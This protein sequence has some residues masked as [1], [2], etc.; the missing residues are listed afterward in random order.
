MAT[1]SAQSTRSSGAASAYAQKDA[2]A[3]SA[4]GAAVQ[5]FAGRLAAV[6]A[7]HGKDG[8]RPMHQRDEAGR[9]VRDEDGKPVAATDSSG[10]TVY[11]SKYVQAYSLVES[12]GRDEL[13]PDDPESWQVAQRC[14]RALAEEVA[15]GHPALVAT[16]TN[17]RTGHV[18][19][20]IIIGAVHPQTGRSL[21]SNVVTHSRLAITHDRVLEEVGFE[22]RE[23]MRE[24]VAAAK[25]D[26]AQQR[27]AVRD[28]AG[29]DEL[30]AS[31]QQRRLTAAENRVRLDSRDERTPAQVR[32]ERR[33]REF[34]LHKLSM[35]DREAAAGLGVAAPRQRFSEIE[36]EARVEDALSDPRATTWDQLDEVGRGH[37]VTIQRRGKDVSYAMMLTDDDGELA[38]PSRSHR[39]RG[40]R[41]GEGF[42]VEDVEA[43]LQRNAEL[44]RQHR[45]PTE[46]PDD[47]RTAEESR[48][49]EEM[50][51]EIRAEIDDQRQQWEQSRRMETEPV[52]DQPPVEGRGDGTPVT[53]VPAEPEPETE[54]GPV[55]RS[56]LRGV[57]AASRGSRTEQR[58]DTVAELEEGYRDRDADAEF[59]QRLSAVGAGERFLRDYGEHLSPQLHELLSRRMQARGIKD[60]QFGTE[61]HGRMS[62]R[63]AEADYQGALDLHADQLHSRTQAGDDAAG[64]PADS[65]PE[66][67]EPAATRPHPAR[68]VGVLSSEQAA[69]A[70]LIAV[71]HRQKAD[72]SALVDFQLA[73]DDPAAAGQQGLHLRVRHHERD[74]GTVSRDIGHRLDGEHYKDLRA[75]AGENVVEVDGRE[76]IAFRGDVRRDLRGGGY[77]VDAS[78][79]RPSQREHLGS[80][81]LAVQRAAERRARDAAEKGSEHR[82]PLSERARASDRFSEQVRH[83]EQQDRGIELGG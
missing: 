39:R 38:E 18:H 75:A 53:A 3:I 64:R 81:V 43:T 77:T 22:Q 47:A 46:E 71:I 69:D 68:Q 31:Q 24:I 48:S 51:A 13:D 23:D 8:V 29:F 5:T 21:D 16:E 27:Q 70:E 42:R 2:V 80:E 9:L 59:E 66:S 62:Q 67:A 14:G 10:R 57:K 41:L 78:Q 45:A 30:T 17:G 60:S 58:I 19:N 33:Q 79:A 6:R 4:V 65:R 44:Q 82:R 54:P 36:L 73:A 56:R 55:F 34:E 35:Q 20:H 1:V 74:D 26:V 37:G 49:V 61:L 12:F 28:E 76:V 52:A 72:G 50:V 7:G 11:E 25:R 40:S 15:A 32:E 83:A 63:I